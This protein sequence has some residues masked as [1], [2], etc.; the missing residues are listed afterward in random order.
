[1]RAVSS[2]PVEELD[3]NDLEIVGARVRDAVVAGRVGPHD[4][5]VIRQACRL[6]L[7]PV[8]IVTG[9]AGA[10]EGD[11]EP[12]MRVHMDRSLLA[13][14]D[15]RFDHTD[16]IV[17]EQHPMVSWVG[18]DSIELGRRVVQGSRVSG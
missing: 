2:V 11:H 18:Q 16:L 1:L 12:P 7:V 4:P 9:E 15:P 8:H 5:T 13:C 6:E 17:L 10:R 3:G 14:R